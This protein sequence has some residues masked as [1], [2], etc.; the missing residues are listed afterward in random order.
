MADVEIIMPRGAFGSSADDSL[1]DMA[2]RV[3]GVGF[4]EEGEW[5]AKYGTTYEN[6]TF[7]MHRYCWCEADD[8]LWCG[9]QCGCPDPDPT[10]LVD[11]DPISAEEYWAANRRIV[12]PLP[13]DVAKYGSAKHKEASAAFDASIK[14]RDRRLQT[15]YA[16]RI[17]TCEPRGMMA[18]RP[19]GPSHHPS[20][21]APNFWFK[22]TD[23]RVWWYKYIGRDMEIDG[24]AGA[25]MLQRVFASHPRGMTLDQAIAETERQEEATARS[26]A[27]MFAS[28][29]IKTKE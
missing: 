17:H 9:G 22:P 4:A 28:L 13:H 2:M 1:L 11:G 26:F 5:A 18:N 12:A 29:G 24:T 3:I 16:E 19:R 14:E 10:Y 20:Q 8:C 15:I 25:D 21:S 6:D 7:M 27:E 23:L